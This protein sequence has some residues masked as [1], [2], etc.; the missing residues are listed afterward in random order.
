LVF[1]SKIGFVASGTQTGYSVKFIHQQ[2]TCKNPY[3][4]NGKRQELL[5]NIQNFVRSYH[6]K[7][8]EAIANA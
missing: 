3:F 8:P 6:M 5:P 4:W 7:S 2:T 1:L